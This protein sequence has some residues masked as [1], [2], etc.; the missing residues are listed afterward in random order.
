MTVQIV[1]YIII[2]MLV[3]KILTFFQTPAAV[4]KIKELLGD[5]SEY[6]S[7]IDCYKNYLFL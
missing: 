6:V 1:L 3:L 5:K 4:K 2:N 7:R